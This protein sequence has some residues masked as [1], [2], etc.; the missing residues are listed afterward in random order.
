MTPEPVVVEPC[1]GDPCGRYAQC[2][3]MNGIAACSCLPG[4]VGS[5]PNCRPE[6]RIHSECPSNL[7]CINE[8]CRDPCPGACGAYAE[9]SVNKHNAVCRCQQGYEGDPFSSCRRITTSEYST[10]PLY[11]MVSSKLPVISSFCNEHLLRVS[12]Y[13]WIFHEIYQL[14]IYKRHNLSII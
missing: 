1:E 14:I 8:K 5:P 12:I 10:V 7:A 9:C 6:C 4:Y 13:V 2:R 3:N 11:C